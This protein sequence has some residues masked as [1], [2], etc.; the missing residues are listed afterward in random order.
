[1]IRPAPTV[2]VIPPY[3]PAIRIATAESNRTEA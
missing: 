1:M 3:R 2:A